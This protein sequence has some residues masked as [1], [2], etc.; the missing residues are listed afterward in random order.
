ML[1]QSRL[2]NN[3]R[4]FKQ[5]SL[6][7]KKK[8]LINSRYHLIDFHTDLIYKDQLNNQILL[9]IDQFGYK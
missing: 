9:Y 3:D 2:K 5:Q 8:I 4:K 1:G 7:M 6:K